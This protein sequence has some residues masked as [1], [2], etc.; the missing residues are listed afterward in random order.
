MRTAG[1]PAKLI[2]GPWSHTGQMGYLGDVN[3]GLAAS[4]ELLGFRGRLADVEL[5]WLRQW[6]SPDTA[7]DSDSDSDSDADAAVPQPELPP[8]LLFVMGINQWREEQ[9]WPLA[10]AVDTDLY[11]RSGD[12]LAFDAPEPEEQTATFTYDPTDPV[13]TTGGNLLMSNEFPPGPFDQAEVEARPDVL[14]YTTDP[15]AEDLEVT[16]RVRAHLTATTDAPTTDW[17]VRLCDVDSKGVS[18]NVA[19]GIVRAVATPGEFTE[20]VVDLWSTSYV[21][22]AGHRIRVQVTSSNFPRW[23]RN[24]N[25]GEPVDQ[26]TESRPAHQEIAHDPARPSRIVLPVIPA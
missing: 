23:D 14:V 12:R 11:L 10:R 13:P 17:V 9:E 22:R 7:A 16:G 5:G 20:Q 4:T 25:T 24:L 2:M 18:H 3:F 15:L 19:D 26:G 8:V 6:L 1:R 21:F